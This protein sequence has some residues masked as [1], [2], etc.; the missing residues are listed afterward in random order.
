MELKDKI[1]EIS[2]LMRDNGIKIL[3]V[4]NQEEEIKIE[5]FPFEAEV[6]SS[7]SPPDDYDISAPI[8]GL[9][10]TKPSDEAKPFA[11]VGNKVKKG[12][13][14]CVIEAMK[15]MNEIVSKNNCEIY[16]VC[17][18]SGKIVEFGQHCLK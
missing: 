15:V 2:Q 12:G 7:L 17:F 1:K 6:K 8:M 14:L 4:K 9:G 3:E 11:S 5:Q 13:V 16:E 18:E 10:Y